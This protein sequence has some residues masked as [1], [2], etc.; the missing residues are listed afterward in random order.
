MNFYIYT[1]FTDGMA[2]YIVLRNSML[3][4]P[5][6]QNIPHQCDQFELIW[7][8]LPV[9]FQISQ[10]VHNQYTCLSWNLRQ[11]IVMAVFA[12]LPHVTRVYSVSKLSTPF[13]K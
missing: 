7:V 1:A 11:K 3:V 4:S 13:W 6:A 9:W 8:R 12:Y 5:V 10:W 2:C